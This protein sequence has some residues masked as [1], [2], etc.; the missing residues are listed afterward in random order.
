V[1]SPKQSH[2]NIKLLAKWDL[3]GNT[4]ASFQHV[5]W[6]KT[7]FVFSA[8][9]LNCYVYNAKECFIIWRCDLHFSLSDLAGGYLLSKD[10]FLAQDR[11]VSIS[12]IAYY[13][14]SG[15][16]VRV[17]ANWRGSSEFGIKYFAL[18]CDAEALFC[19]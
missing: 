10:Y 9:A 1:N 8:D 12:H 6:Q 7:T 13:K 5:E 11:F 2:G 18:A 15:A 19:F 3:G 16:K 4:S 14:N 17:L